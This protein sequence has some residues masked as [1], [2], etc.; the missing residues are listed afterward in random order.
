MVCK[1]EA[2]GNRG[3]WKSNEHHLVGTNDMSI[4]YH[5]LLSMPIPQNTGKIF[6]RRPIDHECTSQLQYL[7]HVPCDIRH[8]PST[9]LLDNDLYI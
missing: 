2:G 1:A 3:Q 8:Q 5:T 7:T 9:G 4:L 6:R